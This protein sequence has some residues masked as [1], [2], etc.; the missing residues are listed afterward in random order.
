M[1]V[2]IA[3]EGNSVSPHFGRCSGYT[4]YEVEE[5]EIRNMKF[6]TSP[7]HQ[8]GVIPTWLNDLGVDLVIAGGAGR[9]AQMM[10][11]QMGIKCILGVTGEIDDIIQEYLEGRLTAGDSLCDHSGTCDNH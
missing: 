2:A 11:D 4:I 9:N 1:K 8:R 6:E 5:N 3:T 10:F 7:Q